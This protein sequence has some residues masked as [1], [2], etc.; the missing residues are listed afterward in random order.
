MAD[1]AT[2]GT[3]D[4]VVHAT[5]IEYCAPAV[6]FGLFGVAEGYLPAAHYPAVYAVKAIAVTVT[7]IVCRRILRDIVPSWNLVLPSV[8]AG[9]GIC[10]LWI[11][12]EQWF[13][14]P[15]L[16]NRVAYNPFDELS[17]AAAQAFLAMRL[18]GMVLLVP[19][20]EEL[21]WRSFLI[22]Y[23]TTANFQSIAPWAYSTGAFWIVAAAGAV[24]HTEWLTAFIVNILFILWM[25][26]T[27]SLFAVVVAHAIT[28]LL[29][30]SFI[31]VTGYW[32]LW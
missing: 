9:V 3:R 13:P 27:R 7:L 24:A 5:A 32:E 1:S 6:V 25:K 21:L 18:Y 28:N 23:A 20:F 4:T 2:L 15:H 8:A 29:L 31:L 30:A 14:Y 10:M 12:L 16:G 11:A 17:P 22:R 19:V 26:Q